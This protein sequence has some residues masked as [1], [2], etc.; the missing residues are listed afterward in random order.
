M[1]NLVYP[2]FYVLLFYCLDLLHT[3]QRSTK[4]DARCSMLYG[5]G[6]MVPNCTGFRTN[7][8]LHLCEGQVEST[9]PAYLERVQKHAGNQKHVSKIRTSQ[10]PKVTPRW[11]YMKV[12]TD[13]QRLGEFMGCQHLGRINLLG[14]GWKFEL[15]TVHN[16]QQDE[17]CISSF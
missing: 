17:A 15:W 13:A 16:S 12:V 9:E 7:R 11:K 14:P 4:K 8:V 5:W 3:P 10:W 6:A 2:C 1:C